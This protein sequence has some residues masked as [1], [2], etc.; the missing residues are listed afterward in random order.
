MLLRHSVHGPLRQRLGL[1][2]GLLLLALTGV[3]VACQSE[4]PAGPEV[5]AEDVWTR[6]AVSMGGNSTTAGGEQGAMG[7]ASMGTGA[8][9]MRLVNTGGEADRLIGA[10]TDVAEVV[11]I[12]ETTIQDDVMK[13]QM[14]PEGLEIPANGEVLLKPGG[15]HI[16]L[17]GMKRDLN[18]GDQ[19]S[20]TLSFDKG[21]PLTI[22]AEVREP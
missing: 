14:L 11:E 19:I 7:H 1:L 5:K 4:S 10:Q 22:D 6:P 20:L 3:L 17:I 16:M 9:F 13:M 2:G 21:A 18:V 12:H 15:Y 8:V